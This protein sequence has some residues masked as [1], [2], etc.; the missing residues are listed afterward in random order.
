MCIATLAGLCIIR[1]GREID[2][3]WFFMGRKRKE[4]YDDWWRC[5]ICF[6]PDLDEMFGVTNT[7]QGIRPTKDLIDILSPD[8]EQIARQLNGK[9]RSEYANIK[10][11][12]ERS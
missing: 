4:N 6:D 1:A 2:Y 11:A 5:V 8:L 7:K 9:I 3:G 10:A 12:S